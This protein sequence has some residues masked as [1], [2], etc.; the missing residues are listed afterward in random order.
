VLDGIQL[1]CRR[2][3]RTL[4]KN[5]LNPILAIGRPFDADTMEVIEAVASPSHP[6]GTVVE[7]VRVGYQQNGSVFRLAQVKVAR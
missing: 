2:L 1:G 6:S 5:G 7:E 4:A 3:E